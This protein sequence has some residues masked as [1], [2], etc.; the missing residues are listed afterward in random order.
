MNGLLTDAE[1]IRRY[2]TAGKAA[3]TLVSPATGRR[4]TYSMKKDILGNQT[5]TYLVSLLQGDD[6]TKD[7]HFIGRYYPPGWNMQRLERVFLKRKDVGY[8]HYSDVTITNG[9]LY[10]ES[11]ILYL[12]LHTEDYLLKGGE[13]W[14]SGRCGRCGRLLTDPESIRCGLGPHCRRK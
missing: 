3:F 14:H 8:D 4:F 11:A 13:F 1:S 6:N 9:L 5:V 10:S 12:L 2:I 7:Y